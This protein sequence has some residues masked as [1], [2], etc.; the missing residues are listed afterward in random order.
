MKKL[1]LIALAACFTFGMAY[2]Q[3]AANFHLNYGNS[4]GSALSVGINKDIEVP[5]WGAT[6]PTPGNGDTITFAHMPLLSNDLYITSRNGGFFPSFGLGLWDDRSF[7]TPNAHDTVWA[8]PP[9]GGAI[10]IVGDVDI[11]VGFMS[12][13]E[14]GFAYLTDPPDP[15]NW[16]YT[17]GAF[18]LLGTF[19]MHTA[20]D[21]LLIGQ[22]VNAFGQG[23][24]PANAGLLWGVVGGSRSVV[25]TTV[26]SQL[27]FSP[28]NAP[29][30]DAPAAG[31]EVKSCDQFVALAGHDDDPTQT[32]TFSADQGTIV[33]S[34]NGVNVTGILTFPIGYTGPI[35]VTLTDG[36][37]PVQVTFNVVAGGGTIGDANFYIDDEDVAPG[38]PSVCVD[39]NLNADACV[40]GFEVMICWDPT[41]LTIIDADP[42]AF[43]NNGLEYF[44]WV[45]DP[46]GAGSARFVWLYD[47]PEHGSGVPFPSGDHPI[48]HLC[49][50]VASGLPFSADVPICFC[51]D[52]NPEQDYTSNTIS[53]VTGNQFFR[54]ERACG[55]IHIAD[56]TT[57]RGDPNMNC[58][59][60]EVADAVLVAQRL[61]QG[62]SVWAGDNSM[63]DNSWYDDNGQFHASC[64]RHNNHNDNMQEAAADL[65][66]NSRADIADL[67]TFINI[68]NGFIYPKTDR[69]V[70]NA[71]IYMNDGAVRINSNVE[72]GGTLV[73]IAH[74]G[75]IGTPVVANG[76]DM[77]Y[78]DANGVLSVVVFSKTAQRIAAGDQPLFT[79]TGVGTITEASAADSYGELM[80][81]RV[82]APLPT[83]FSVAQNYPNPFNG[84][85]LIKFALPNES[86]VNINIYS[87]TGQLVE[88]LKGHFAAGEQ[89]MIW[90]ANV[91]S[92]VYFAKVSAGSDSRTLRMTLLK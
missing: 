18:Q 8:I 77:L 16:I 1:L 5:V 88:T 10:V 40:G 60:Y 41:A 51:F 45:H 15:Q 75:E 64:G 3:D 12:Q 37:D 72:V 7:L 23:H 55:T 29:V 27:Y 50:R 66:G 63:P 2:A 34:Q 20:S 22:T 14:L 46:M 9:R 86:D 32:L 48:V 68:L 57:Y 62:F 44:N 71:S 24:N 59:E 90:D 89:S 17:L 38:T 47:T 53:D 65:N 70:G 31:A 84:K 39:I 35:T 61:I 30:I 92:G 21:P 4:D 87:V 42:T 79:L 28:N 19:R 33:Q 76:M 67:V 49:F 13:S 91:A 83:S 73:R 6:D 58:Y 43:I 36:T 78:N 80:E 26:F 25:P 54:P 56:P 82:G 81:S 11:P 85:T 74:A 69:P 52:P